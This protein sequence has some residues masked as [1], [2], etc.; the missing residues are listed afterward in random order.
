MTRRMRATWLI[1]GLSVAVSVAAPTFA[2]E[3]SAQPDAASAQPGSAGAGAGTVTVEMPTEPVALGEPVSVEARFE[4][5]AGSEVIG[6]GVA[7]NAF[8]EVLEQTPHTDAGLATQHWTVRLAVF[9]PGLYAADA[10]VVRLLDSAGAAV[11]LRSGPF[12]IETL[13]TVDPLNPG[14]PAPSAFPEPVVTRDDRPIWVGATLL[15]FL[16]GWLSRT[17]FARRPAATEVS[18]PPPPRPAWEVALE[19]LERLETSDHYGRGSAME[20]HA[21]LSEILREFVGR[22]F[23]FPAVE[24]TTPEIRHALAVHA[25]GQQ[26]RQT[27]EILRILEDTDMVKFAR[28]ALPED[29]AAA[30]L[31]RARAVVLD[32]SSRETAAST[33]EPAAGSS[34]SAREG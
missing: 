31:M 10:L 14:D 22:H 28:Q 5:P 9:R 20:Y 11:E 17:L 27:R 2:Q 12:R 1:A 13:A 3:G 32:L 15:V 34:T 25:H 29:D 33:N 6:F 26:V 30:M 24:S 21:E 16:I 8:V 23:D 4:L 18:A 7:G 19:R